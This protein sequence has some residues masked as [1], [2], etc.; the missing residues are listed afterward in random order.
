MRLDIKHFMHLN[1]SH[2]LVKNIR[3][4]ILNAV[5]IFGHDSALPTPSI[6]GAPKLVCNF[7]KS[8]IS[9]CFRH[10]TH[11]IQYFEFVEQNK[12]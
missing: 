6:L 7:C 11:Y 2:F 12:I 4:T 1:R 3:F 10:R 9:F 8:H 5:K